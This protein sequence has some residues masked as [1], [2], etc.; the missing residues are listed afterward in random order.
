MVEKENDTIA[1]A[2]APTMNAQ[3]ENNNAAVNAATNPAASPPNKSDLKG[4][5]TINPEIFFNFVKNLVLAFYFFEAYYTKLSD[6]PNDMGS[7][8]GEDSVFVQ[9]EIEE[10]GREVIEKIKLKSIN[11]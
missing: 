8:Y 2:A 1:V 7:F 9:D 4:F 3:T 6:Q 10:I 5:L 11:R